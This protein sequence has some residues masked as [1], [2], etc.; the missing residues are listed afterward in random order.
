MRTVS[1]PDEKGS[2]SSSGADLREGNVVSHGSEKASQVG[3]EH[4]SNEDDVMYV[5]GEPVIMTGSDVSRFLVD[6]RDDGDPSL[7][8]R[9]LLIGTIFACLGAAL[10]Q[11]YLFK[12]VQVSVSTVVLLLLIHSV[13]VTWSRILPRRSSLE[14]TR[15]AKLGPF[16]EFIN[17]GEFRIKE[18]AIATLIASTA[19]YGSTAVLNFAVQRLYYNTDIKATTAVF[20][21]FSTA[22]FGYGLC[23][24][25]R[26]LTVYPSEM[27]YWA[28]LPT[29]S[30]FQSLHFNTAANHKRMKLFWM[31]F[32]GMFLWEI[33]PSY[34]F[35]LLNGF[36]VFCLA[37]QHAPPSVQSVFTNL[38]GGANSNEGL[39]LLSISF[40]WQYITSVFMSFPLTQ[41]VNTW[42]GVGLC[43]IILS[44]IYY[45]D[46]WNAKNFPMLSTSIFSSN[47]SVYDQSAVFGTTFQLNQTALIE[48]GLPYMTGSNVWYSATSNLAIGGLLAHCV[49]FWGPYF[50]DTFRNVRLGTQQDPHWRAM[51]KYEEVPSRWYV[52]LLVI[53]F[54][55]GRINTFISGLIVIFKGQTTLPWYSYIVALL[56]GSFVTPFSQTLSARFGSGVATNQL[57]K[58]VGGAIVPGRPV[59][60]LYFTMWSHDIVSQSIGLA[61]DLKIGQYLKIPP[62]GMFFTQVWG[63]ILV[64]MVSIVNSERNTILSPTGTNVWSGQVV[65]SLNSDAVMW[66]LAKEVYGP[67]GQYFIVPLSFLIGIVMTVI[68]WLIWRRWPRIGPIKVDSII[69]PI[70]CMYSAWMSSGVNSTVTSCI[71]V[72]IISQFWLRSYNPSWFRKYNYILGGALDGGAQVMV[73]ILSFAVFGASGTPRPFPSWAGNP[74]QGNVD[75][76]NGN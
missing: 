42:I 75:Y 38:F 47:G 61:T 28:S 65:Q 12:P 60:N 69:L 73:F 26:P 40:D 3:D 5:K 16:L 11:I 51:Q 4:T 67:G 76:C 25:I 18:H 17:P 19:S 45:S 32:T 55:S 36:N 37:S 39:G 46:A 74:A 8:F 53:S 48:V 10:C 22:C 58:M 44:A 34:I 24:L 14:G 50:R 35:P 33:F 41:Q 13:G 63:T 57:M 70:I 29:I 30:I 21:T 59:A 68:Q 54:V 64:I 31:A 52:C 56:L 27:V 72:G 62:R 1:P 49:C 71:L 43:Y 23:G 6:L 7:T 20:A 66:S 9:S 2:T 15:Y